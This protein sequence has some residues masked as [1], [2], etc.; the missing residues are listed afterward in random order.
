MSPHMCHPCLRTCVTYVSGL[1]RVAGNVYVNA[2]PQSNAEQLG[3]SKEALGFIGEVE[4]S[5]CPIVQREV[6]FFGTASTAAQSILA[7]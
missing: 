7:A 4:F 1:Y 2:P 5:C 3:M 6:G